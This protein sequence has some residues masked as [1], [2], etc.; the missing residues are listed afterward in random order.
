MRLRALLIGLCSS[1]LLS[2][3]VSHQQI[4]QM[5]DEQFKQMREQVPI[6][7]SA[8][9]R[10]FVDCVAQ[11]IIAELEPP[12]SEYNWDLEV[13]SNEAVNAF[14]MPGGKI[15]VYDGIF[16]TAINQDQLA[17]VIGHE[18]AHVTRDHSLDR[19][20]R[21]TFTG[22][23]LIGIEIAGGGAIA[24]GAAMGA[25]LLVLKPYGRGQ[26]SEA[27][28]VGLVYMA[29]AGFNP[30]ASVELWRNMAKQGGEAPPEWM[31]THPSDSTRIDALQT[32]LAKVQSQY[33][34]ARAA[35]KRPSCT[36]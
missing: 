10:A 33:E 11:A 19:V 6:S 24:Q 1:A 7:E 23:A 4:A 26:E 2:A 13:F 3:C 14:A 20:N 35:G 12:Y 17:A 8:A 36:R 9:D 25:D 29:K 31:S 21:D 32:Q 28:I 5:S 18:V 30:N 34:A 15:G 16:A 22:V 27:D